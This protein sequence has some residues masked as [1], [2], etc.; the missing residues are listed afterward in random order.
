VARPVYAGPRAPRETCRGQA[1]YFGY[2]F[3]F[4]KFTT[5]DVAHFVKAYATPA[6]LG[7][8]FEMYRAFPANAQ[9][10]AAQRGPNDVPRRLHNWFPKWQ[11]VSAQ[12][13]AR[14]RSSALE[15]QKKNL[16]H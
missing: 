16:H 1:D 2:F 4:G 3:K 13:D 14:P 11:R 6:Q 15:W 10:N 8:V 9:F 7:A 5:S 12:T